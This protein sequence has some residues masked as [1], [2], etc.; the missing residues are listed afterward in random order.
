MKKQI[1]LYAILSV[2]CMQ[3]SLLA[4]QAQLPRKLIP[5]RA[6]RTNFPWSTNIQYQEHVGHF[7]F[8][9]VHIE[10]DSYKH[11]QSCGFIFIP[12]LGDVPFL[13]GPLEHSKL[14]PTDHWHT[15][16]FHDA[17]TKRPL[18]SS[19][20]QTSEIISVLKTLVTI[21]KNYDSIAIMGESRGG[22]AIVNT[23]AVLN[24]PGH[25]L[26]ILADICETLRVTLIE[27]I[28][29]GCIVLRAPLILFE[30]A[31]ASQTNNVFAKFAHFI[32]APL[33]SGFKYNP[34]GQ[35]ALHSTKHWSNLGIP[36]LVCFASH[37]QT[38]G[39]NLN[40]KFYSNL[41]SH[42]GAEKTFVYTFEGTHLKSYDLVYEQMLP[43]FFTHATLEGFEYN[44]NKKLVY[45][46]IET[47]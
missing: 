16:Y 46:W 18:Q 43:Y 1:I 4:I 2:L 25:K 23:I 14:L 24:Q 22:A 5:W 6:N 44:P 12:G 39:S 32:I 8:T 17:Q 19:L 33:V 7:T 40:T 3:Q 37:D 38:L 20:G 41:K 15:V 30:D 34:R 47:V 11:N 27:K 31:A 29:L 21:H 42:N 35:Q 13:M 9:K 45:Q 26:L 10:K 36:T 28:K